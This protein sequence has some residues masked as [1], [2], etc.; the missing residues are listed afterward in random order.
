MPEVGVGGR[1]VWVGIE[2]GGGDVDEG[3]GGLM[4][5]GGGIGVLL[6]VAL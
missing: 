5:V 2:V 6:E 1:A 4:D 3:G